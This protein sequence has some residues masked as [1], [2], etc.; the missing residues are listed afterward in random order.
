[1]LGCAGRGQ[2][3][4]QLD[5]LASMSFTFRFSATHIA[6]TINLVESIACCNKS[7]L[8]D[9]VPIYARKT[10]RQRKT[11]DIVG[12]GANMDYPLSC[13][14]P[15]PHIHRRHARMRALLLNSRPTLLKNKSM[16]CDLY[17]AFR[18]RKFRLGRT[19]IQVTDDDP[20]G[21]MQPTCGLLQISHQYRWQLRCTA[22]VNARSVL[23][24]LVHVTITR[25]QG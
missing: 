8:T 5:Y 9:P 22:C 24:F 4:K 23:L 17:S 12:G 21:Y 15:D 16:S 19:P 18:G 7:M 20:V 14:T 2:P 3:W 6:L 13:G 1:M 10:R 11:Q 25:G